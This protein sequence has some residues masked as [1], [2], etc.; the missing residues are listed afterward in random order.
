MDTKTDLGK[1]VTRLNENFELLYSALEEAKQHFELGYK[2]CAKVLDQVTIAGIFKKE[3][4]QEL[5]KAMEE[6]SQKIRTDALEGK[7][8][9]AEIQ[10]EVHLS[11]YKEI[12]TEAENFTHRERLYQFAKTDIRNDICNKY[13]DIIKVANELNVP[14]MSLIVK[15][16][17]NAGEWKVIN[18]DDNSIIFTG[19]V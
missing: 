8:E 2:L 12:M 14:E 17:V 4:M 3:D 11:N 10:D 6:K 7:I 1:E 16:D 18:K 15:D 13:N 9:F 19:K 5:L